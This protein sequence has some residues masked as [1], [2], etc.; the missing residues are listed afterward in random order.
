MAEKIMIDGVD[1]SRCE[2]YKE[3]IEFE[4]PYGTISSCKN[5]GF[6]T[7]N[8]PPANISGNI[9]YII[10]RCNEQKDC[11]YKQLARKTEECEKLKQ[12]FFEMQDNFACEMQARLYH[13]SEWLK[14]SEELQA[15]KQKVKELEEKLHFHEVLEFQL[16]EER[17]INQG[18]EKE[19]EAYKQAL[20][21]IE[22]F[23]MIYS[24]N[25]DCYET[26]YKYILQKCEVLK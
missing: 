13:Q 11:Y 19:L 23:C 4:K 7:H 17:G 24:D 5:C 9:T 3:K 22:E 15:E 12:D 8:L 14:M 6:C 2:H 21:E 18:L 26:I 20:A 25:H 16:K 10:A 1:V